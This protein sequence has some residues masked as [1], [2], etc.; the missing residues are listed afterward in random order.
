[1]NDPKDLKLDRFFTELCEAAP[2]HRAPRLLWAG[3]GR[4]RQERARPAVRLVLAPAF[5]ALVVLA[6]VVWTH[7]GFAAEL[8]Q[9][10]RAM[11]FGAMD[12]RVGEAKPRRW[13]VVVESGKPSVIDLGS[14]EVLFLVEE[15]GTGAVKL[16][17]EVS[18]KLP[19]GTKK[20]IAK[21]R[22]MT[23]RGAAA[24]VIIADAA[25]KKPIFQVSLT[26]FKAS[27]KL[28]ASITEVKQ[29]GR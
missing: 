23:R 12:I 11:L 29:D 15:D 18:Q 13:D 9:R 10:A 24:T 8:V 22:V 19:D 25:T 2:L 26:A 21:P 7:P 5:A 4:A 28:E 6:A 20:L 1:M 3:P 17:L 27:E 14:H 16:S